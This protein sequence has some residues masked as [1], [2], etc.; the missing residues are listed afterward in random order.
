MR[1]TAL[2]AGLAAFT[3]GGLIATQ[4]PSIKEEC[5]IRIYPG[6]WEPI[7]WDMQKGHPD[8][9]VMPYWGDFHPDGTWEPVTP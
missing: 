5:D 9:C 8:D 1:Y 4:L 2:F 6:L 7:G 3:V